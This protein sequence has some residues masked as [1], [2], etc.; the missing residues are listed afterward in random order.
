MSNLLFDEYPIVISREL[1]KLIGLNEAIVL[2]QVHYWLEI[3]RKANKN[4]HDGSFWTYNSIKNWQ[5]DNFNFWSYDTVKRTFSRLEKSGLLIFDNY[6]RD[7][8]DKTKWYTINN[9]EV[10]KLKNAIGAK[11]TNGKKVDKSNKNTKKQNA[12]MHEC[13]LTPSLGQIDP[14]HRYNLP[15][16]LPEI[17]SKI[18]TENISINLHGEGLD[19][20]KNIRAYIENQIEF[21]VLKDRY[22]HNNVINDMLEVMVDI[23]CSSAPTIRVNKEDK[24]V[25]IVKSQ[26]MKLDF[27][28][29]EYVLRSFE[30]QTIKAA[31]V[32]AYLAT[33]LYNAPMTINAYYSNLVS[34]DL[35]NNF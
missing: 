17:T 30:S 15:Q 4:F 14:M 23:M 5:K 32:R 16:P 22:P 13:K 33:A 25:E 9:H 21:D 34:H 11:C 10:E 3:N 31:N 2:Q 6:N 27:G 8:R 29:I 28:H 7:P 20:H 26:F 19:N 12:P 35:A 18:T 24:P 1:A